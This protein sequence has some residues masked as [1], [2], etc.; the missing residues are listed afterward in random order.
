MWSFYDGKKWAEP[1]EISPVVLND[2]DGAYRATMSAVTRG[3]KEIFFIATGLKSVLRWDG[4]SWHKEGVEVEDGGMLSL[5]GEV[6]TLFEAGK[7]NRRWKERRWGRPAVIR[8]Y[9]RRDNG[10]WDK[11]VALTEKFNIDEYRALT[12]Y[13]VP[14]YSPPNFVPLA[15]SDADEGNIK[16]L[17]VPVTEGGLSSSSQ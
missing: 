12:G 10:Q 6:V 1:E 3:D 9:R 13:S 8:Y 5:A 14:P 4:E 16:L 7:V 15:Y 2:M 11:A 17:K